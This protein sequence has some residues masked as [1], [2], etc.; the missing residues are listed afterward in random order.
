M[1][2]I[3]ANNGLVVPGGFGGP[4]GLP[5][6]QRPLTAVTN[7]WTWDD[8]RKYPLNA[9]GSEMRYSSWAE[10]AL[11][12]WQ[13]SGLTDA[14]FVFLGDA[15]EVRFPAQTARLFRP[16]PPGDVEVVAHLTG[17]QGGESVT[18][19]AMIGPVIVNSVGAGIGGSLYY[20]A[21]GWYSWNVSSW[22]YASTAIN[23]GESITAYLDGQSY[24]A[25][26]AKL[27]TSGVWRVSGNQSTWNAQ[28]EE[29]WT[30]S[31]FT[32]AYVGIARLYTLG[33][34]NPRVLIHRFRVTGGK[35]VP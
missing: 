29:S 31:A 13:R 24:W 25:S 5:P 7:G 26:L 10:M 18:H 4:L 22:A 17:P 30:P 8:P 19:A 15:V 28:A 2:W 32:P 1:A 16:C 27:G 9:D 35:W 11:D 21:A 14:D 12:G 23:A 34:A 33:G 3:E 20:N 6:G